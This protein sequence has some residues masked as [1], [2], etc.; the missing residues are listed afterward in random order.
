M[1]HGWTFTRVDQLDVY[2]QTF[3]HSEIRNQ[4]TSLAR[5]A[6]DA[7]AADHIERALAK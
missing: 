6:K 3:A 7:G 5:Q 1:W 2:A 4:I